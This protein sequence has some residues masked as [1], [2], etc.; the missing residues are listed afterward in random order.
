VRENFRLRSRSHSVPDKAPLN[1]SQ[2]TFA[3]F[4]TTTCLQSLVDRVR[5]GEGPL[6]QHCA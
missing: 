3:I 1:E 4:F 5:D 2:H 6:A